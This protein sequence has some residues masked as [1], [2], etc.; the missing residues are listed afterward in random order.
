MRKANFKYLSLDVSKNVEL[1]QRW[2]PAHVGGWHR[3]AVGMS[4][5]RGNVWKTKDSGSMAPGGDSI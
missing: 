1:F 3:P 5:P 4:R 2:L